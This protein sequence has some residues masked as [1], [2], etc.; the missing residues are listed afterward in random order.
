ME[1]PREERSD[2]AAKAA[3]VHED[4]EASVNQVGDQ[5]FPASHDDDRGQPAAAKEG[6]GPAPAPAAPGRHD[7]D[8]AD[9]D[10]SDDSGRE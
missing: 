9:Q 3:E 2:G 7:D 6:A 8:A 1:D 5:P 10:D 4:H